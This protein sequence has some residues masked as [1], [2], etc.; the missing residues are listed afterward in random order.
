MT[1]PVMPGDLAEQVRDHALREAI[2]LDLVVECELAAA[3]GTSP[4][5]PPIT[6]LT[7]PAWPKW[8]SP[9][10]LPSPWPPA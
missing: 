10:F 9:R 8:L 1:N 2:R 5:W 7:M 6:R 4:Q 3:P